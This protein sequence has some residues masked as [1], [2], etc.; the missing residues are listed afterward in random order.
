MMSPE[1]VCSRV[2]ERITPSPGEREQVL[3]L[4][5]SIMDKLRAILAEEGIDAQVRLEGSLAKDTWLSGEADVDIFVRFKPEV[6]PSFLKEDFMEMARRATEGLKQIERYAEHPY[7]ECWADGIRVNVVP[8]YDVRKGDWL[9]ATDRTPYHTE[10]VK[11]HLPEELKA[12]VRLLKKFM[13]GIGAY[14]AELK[15]GGFS[16]YLC[17]L[18]IIFYGG[19]LKALRGALRWRKG[20]VIDL[21]GHYEGRED[22]A[23]EFFRHHL[24]VVDPVDPGRNVAAP[25]RLDKMC[26]FMVAAKEFL[27]RPSEAFFFPRKEPLDLRALEANLK[28][29]GTSLIAICVRT[30]GLVPDVLWG[31]L[32]RTL[33]GLKGS[34]GRQGFKVLRTGAWS[35]EE[36]KAVLL[37]ELETSR[38]PPVEKRIGPPVWVEEH[39]ERFLRKNM[40][41]PALVCG[42]YIEGDRWVILIRR[43]WPDASEFLK[44]NLLRGGGRHI[45]VAPLLAQ[46]VQEGFEV[47]TDMEVLKLCRGEEGF[48]GFLSEFLIGR[49]G[50]LVGRSG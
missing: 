20:V 44:E 3:A 9:S 5:K 50:W 40:A 14:G 46:K 36:D 49:P 11:E 1:E 41:D 28:S 21:E 18:L 29:R 12:D 34:L 31:L 25:V 15:V 19:F 23:R 17:E 2:L 8:C 24:I 37:L 10:Y 32:Y 13:K 26:L 47:L 39:V 27:T 22:E 43:K 42:P 45:G 4:A 35:N 30:E 6:K 38:L 33:R 7:L 48:R 16:G